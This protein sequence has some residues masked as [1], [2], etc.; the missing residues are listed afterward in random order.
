METDSTLEALAQA[1]RVRLE[2]IADHELRDRDTAAHLK[3]LQTASEA[4]E[5]CA[6]ALPRGTVNPRLRHYL[7]GR[8]YNKALEWIESNG[9]ISRANSNLLPVLCCMM[10]LTSSSLFAQEAPNNQPASEPLATK[11]HHVGVKNYFHKCFPLGSKEAPVT[12]NEY[13]AFL[14]GNPAAS[15]PLFSSDTSDPTDYC[16]PSYM[17]CIANNSWINRVWGEHKRVEKNDCI[18]RHNAYHF[19]YSVIPGRGTFIIDSVSNKFV[20]ENFSNWRKCPTVGELCDYINDKIEG[21]EEEAQSIRTHYPSFYA[22]DIWEDVDLLVQVGCGFQGQM[23][24]EVYKGYFGPSLFN[25]SNESN[26]EPL[27]AKVV[28]GM[29]YDRPWSLE[30]SLL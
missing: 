27:H 19:R 14:K 12:A 5:A 17:N 1:L 16:E 24:T 29:E 30:W 13:C 28:E 11:A 3:K 8:S 25:F 10:L 6:E 21:L 23:Q 18:T 15:T 22:E 9:E 7:E 20:A 4:I 2:V 26:N